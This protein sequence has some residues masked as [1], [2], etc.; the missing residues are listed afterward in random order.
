M[1]GTAFHEIF[2]DVC[3][4]R[5]LPGLSIGIVVSLV[6]IVIEVSFATMIFS[7]PLEMYVRK[8]IGMALAGTTL[9]VLVTSIF[10]GIRSVVA[11]PQDAPVP[12]CG[13]D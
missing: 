11:I 5:F 10:S 4:S 12:R 3:S 9:F 7:G 13:R 6:L 2:D 1:A 8:G